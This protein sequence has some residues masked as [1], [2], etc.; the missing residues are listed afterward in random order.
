[1]IGIVKVLSLWCTSVLSDT[2]H[3]RE[4]FVQGHGT[5]YFTHSHL[6]LLSRKKQ[7]KKLEIS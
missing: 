6:V 2:H 1:M 5:K 4:I 7:R 3:Q